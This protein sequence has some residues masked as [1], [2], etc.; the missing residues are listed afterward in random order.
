MKI[1]EIK[2]GEKFVEN[3]FKIFIFG[4]S[5][6]WCVAW[7]VSSHRIPVV[8]FFFNDFFSPYKLSILAICIRI[9]EMSVGVG[10]VSHMSCQHHISGLIAV[11]K[12]R[13][14][15]QF[16][17]LIA[18]FF[19]FRCTLL[20]CHLINLFWIHSIATSTKEKKMKR[21]TEKLCEVHHMLVCLLKAS[22]PPQS[23]RMN[24]I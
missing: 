12:C 6:F 24:L 7:G 21:S 11:I 9:A 13:L 22:F 1:S 20:L 23:A 2:N 14:R 16:S 19:Y 18:L 4:A 10:K 17:F 8:N 3:V 5:Y 15:V